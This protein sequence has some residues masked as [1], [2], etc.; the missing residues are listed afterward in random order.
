MER[1]GV[2]LGLGIWIYAVVEPQRTN[3]ELV[4]QAES[5]GVAHVAGAGHVVVMKAA[6]I[7]EDGALQRPVERELQL[8]VPDR[9]EFAAERVA[10][11]VLRAEL[12]LGETAHG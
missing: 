10:G 5:N 4:A 2:F 8:G 3:G 11:F 6:C 12:A 1:A 7:D 9:V